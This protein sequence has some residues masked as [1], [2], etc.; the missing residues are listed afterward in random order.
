MI[1]ARLTIALATALAGA[2]LLSANGQAQAGPQGKKLYCWEEEGRK[3]CGD[4]LPADAA[5]NARTVFNA[6]TGTQVGEVARALTGEERAALEAAQARAAEEAKAE[7]ARQRRELAMVESYATEDDLRRA[8]QNRIALMDDTV[9][10]SRMAIGNLREGLLSR[11]RRAN[12]MELAGKPVEGELA[13][14]IA[15]QHA[16]LEQQRQILASNLQDRASLDNE[17][18]SAVGRYR[19]L[20]GA[21]EAEPAPEAADA[22][23]PEASEP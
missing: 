21:A 9:L 17:L 5:D 20:T 14:A 16:A 1:Q 6:K 13:T 18:E 10:A 23:A 19:E 4:A 12:E 15:T 7:A 11:L 8:F 3:I 22:P 2:A